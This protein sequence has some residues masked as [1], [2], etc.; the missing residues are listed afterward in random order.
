[1]WQV[2]RTLTAALVATMIVLLVPSV[3]HTEGV[4][5]SPLA[6]QPI[7]GTAW[8]PDDLG[9]VRALV[10]DGNTLYLGG[11]F[12]YLGPN[13]G[14]G[15]RIDATTGTV[16]QGAPF[17][18]GNVLAA[19][20]DGDG[21]FYVGGNLTAV[22]GVVVQRLA[23]ISSD[24]AFDR[25]FRPQL[26]G[27]VRA[28]V[29]VGDIVYLAGDFTH[30]DGQER[31]HL[32]AIDAATGALLPWSPSTDAPVHELA[33]AGE[34]LYLRGTFSSVNGAE[35]HRLAAVD[36]ASG[37]VTSWNPI[38]YV[39]PN[40]A[41][42][43][44]NAITATP[45]AVYVGGLFSSIGGA[46]RRNL[47]ALDTVAG[48]ATAWTPQP[49]GLNSVTDLA[50]DGAR[51]YVTTPGRVIAV[52]TSDGTVV[53]WWV[54]TDQT[55]GTVAI[56]GDRVYVSGG[57]EQVGN[58]AR[59]F[60]AALDRGTGQVLEWSPAAARPPGAFAFAGGSVYVGGGFNSIGGV[61]R[62]NLAALDLTTGRATDWRVDANGTIEALAL[63]GG[64]LYA[65]GSFTE[66][67]G[68]PRLRLAAVNA[69]SGAVEPWSADTNGTVRALA[70]RG[71]TL[72][73]GGAF[74]SVGGLGRNRLAAVDGASAAVSAWQP[75]ADATVTTL[76]VGDDEVYVGGLFS[77][78]NGQPRSRLAAVGVEGGLR[79]WNPS[80]GGTAQQ[81]TDN[82]AGTAVVWSLAVTPDTI[83]L[84]GD[85]DTVGNEPRHSLA[86]VDASSGAARPWAGSPSGSV[87]AVAVSGSRLY[88]GGSFTSLA[89]RSHVSLASYDLASGE[90]DPWTPMWGSAS[91]RALDVVGGSVIAGGFEFAE[92]SV[93]NHDF[94]R[95]HG[96][97]IFDASLPT[98]W[99]LPTV[100][101]AAVVGNTVTCSNDVEWTGQPT[102]FA[103]SWYV[104]DQLVVGSTGQ[105][106]T[107]VAGDAGRLLRC[108]VTATNDTGPTTLLATR[109]AVSTDVTSTPS[110]APSLTP[111]PAPSP[112]TTD[113][114][115]MD[116][117]PPALTL[118]TP[119]VS[120]YSSKV[121]LRFVVNQP[122]EIRLKVQAPDRRLVQVARRT[123]AAGSRTISWDR[124][125]YGQRAK[126]GVRYRLVLVATAGG[127]T[128][129]RVV[130]VRL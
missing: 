99:G 4:A 102:S 70:A 9:E 19:A 45:D 38:P 33:P 120:K 129:R 127:E 44:V 34:T 22:D 77:A 47:A 71:S 27:R 88:A 39:A 13:T 126:S 103:Y 46:P 90:E 114:V 26:D 97:A 111:S 10:R 96:L 58:H 12:S 123:V 80:V 100:D 75:N 98:R 72:Y 116:D 61:A 15:G 95:R 105:Q 50:T 68:E 92:G 79:E 35:R 29:R 41:I 23:H 108:G 16:A 2:T 62:E 20:D 81:T 31:G 91:V 106:Y 6:I 57:F 84:G 49:T 28:L 118:S 76:A 101:G 89:A 86:A 109:T 113:D 59:R 122:A 8:V 82:T 56:D 64:S 52:P 74:T 115:S 130:Y 69:V 128:V 94:R 42:P 93:L 40:V 66:V 67:G 43:T 119:T 54:G 37:A 124:Y 107:V 55:P 5:A 7:P 17:L 78:V 83:Y 32:A 104:D 30:I 53:D 125:I 48:A 65:G 63:V 11:T 3:A 14:T 85:F 121:V 36:L 60:L 73:V 110:P 25:A 51:V 21:G 18:E 1:M 117:A 24:G 87:R 112:T